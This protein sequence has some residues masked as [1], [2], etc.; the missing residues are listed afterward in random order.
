MSIWSMVTGRTV[1]G[2]LLVA[3]G[4][5]GIDTPGRKRGGLFGSLFAAIIGIVFV[6]LGFSI[7]QHSQPYADG[8][9]VTGQVTAV[10]SS[11]DNKGKLMYTRAV[12]FTPGNG[13][14]VQFTEAGSSS[15]AASVG[16]PVKVSYRAADP[17]DARIV[18]ENTWI[19]L[20]IMGLGALVAVVGALTFVVRL[21]TL[22]AGIVL[23][24]E[25]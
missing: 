14:P 15:T 10:H 21:I 18:G 24:A 5:V 12:T 16:D 23:L 9:T 25:R 3:D 11:T 8:V 22:I 19:P 4:L 13:Q 20:V 2:G 1:A 6:G 17:R 7:Q